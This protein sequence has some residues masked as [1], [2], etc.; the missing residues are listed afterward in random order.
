MKLAFIGFGEAGYGLTKGLRQGGLREEIY[1]FDKLWDTPPYGDV[2]MKRAAETGAVSLKSL[3]ELMTVSD[4]VI[5][6]V[7]TSVAI[8]VAESSAPFLSEKHLYVDVNAA[9]PMVKEQVSDIVEKTGASFVDAAMMGAIPVFLHR[10]PILASGNGAAL[11]KECMEPFEMRITRIGGKPG[12]A[13]A[14][15]MFRSI[16]MKGLVA[17]LL[18]TLNA[19]H[20]YDVD[21]TVLESLAETME[22]SSF[23]ETVRL[24]VTRGVVHAERRAHEMEE[25]IKTLEGID[26]LPTMS[27]ATKEKLS[28][29]SSLG[30]KEHFGGETPKTL[31]EV[32]NAIEEKLERGNEVP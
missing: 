13:S 5:S 12:Q 18:E 1:F 2:I 11:F 24:L 30:L 4:I 23:L 22:K 17:L 14:I 15:K 7:T 3:E 10:V 21:D 27:Q 8:S 25:V 29:C 32:L 6:C 9:S 31:T 28:W 20:R 19:T 26:V 16:F